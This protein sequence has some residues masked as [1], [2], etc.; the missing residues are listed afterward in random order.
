MW[1]LAVIEICIRFQG[2]SE[3]AVP[4][5]VREVRPVSRS[6]MRESRKRNPRCENHVFGEIAVDVTMK[7]RRV[8][9][10]RV[11]APYRRE[12]RLQGVQC[13]SVQS[14]AVRAPRVIS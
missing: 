13:P 3:V 6:E 9:L 12:L 7:A 11:H 2:Q 14:T 8:L 1:R 10:L 4:R 5:G